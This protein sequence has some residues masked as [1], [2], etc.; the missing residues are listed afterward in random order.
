[1]LNDELI[2]GCGKNSLQII[3]LQRQGKKPQITKQFLL[4][5]KIEKGSLLK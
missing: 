1:M 4:G 2:V 5:S 3:E